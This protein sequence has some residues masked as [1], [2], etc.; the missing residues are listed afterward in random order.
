MAAS[1]WYDHSTFP[2]TG[3]F[4]S[5]SAMRA[6]LLRIENGISAKLPDLSGNGG[7]IIAV[8]AAATALEAITTTG[9][10]SGVR[11]TSPTIATPIISTPVITKAALKSDIYTEQG[12]LTSKN[13][14]ATLTMAELLTRI[15]Q[16][17]GAAN[18][19]L[20]TPTAADIE[21]GLTVTAYSNIAFDFCVVATS[22][23]NATLVAGVGITLTG[24]AT[25]TNGTSGT[26]RVRRFGAT[27]YRVYR[28]A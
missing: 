1:E 18:A 22:T 4:G 20:T 17:T 11:A 24:N 7:E 13:A 16:Y 9:T 8:N 19:N 15:V 26:F 12:A 3:A 10:G 14:A 5:S 27:D 6:E 23:G 25:V 28:I 21:A 2:S